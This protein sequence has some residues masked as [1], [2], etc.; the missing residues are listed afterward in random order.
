MTGPCRS[1]FGLLEI[2]AWGF[3]LYLLRQSQKSAPILG[4]LVVE[5]SKAIIMNDLVTMVKR[6]DMLL[7]GSTRRQPA[8]CVVRESV[9][10]VNDELGDGEEKRKTTRR[11]S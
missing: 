10:R 11:K 7:N 8:Q 3:R 2:I 5:R 6:P 4:L 9:V 1:S